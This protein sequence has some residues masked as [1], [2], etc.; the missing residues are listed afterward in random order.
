LNLQ[1]HT[2]FKCLA[3]PWAYATIS[4]GHHECSKILPTHKSQLL[5][6]KRYI[7][8]IFG[9]WLPPVRDPYDTWNR[10][11][12]ELNNWG[13]LEWLFE[14]P[15]K[16]TTFLNLNITIEGSSTAFSTFQKSMNLP[17]YIPLLYNLSIYNILKTL[18]L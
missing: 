7:D 10:F 16:K 5:Y 12:S 2:G 11:K 1:D 6:Y 14:E 18:C 13:S 17:L 9:I 8:N 15:S 4:Y 3:Q